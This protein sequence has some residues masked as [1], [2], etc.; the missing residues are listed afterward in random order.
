MLDKDGN[1]ISNIHEDKGGTDMRRDTDKKNRTKIIVAVITNICTVVAAVI[2]TYGVMNAKSSPAVNNNNNTIIL[3]D[4]QQINLEEYN[5]LVAN[6]RSL[7]EK[8]ATLPS[9]KRTTTAAPARPTPLTS[10]PIVD[11]WKSNTA[12]FDSFE[13]NM[14]RDHLDQLHSSGIIFGLSWPS[15]DS[16]YCVYPLDGKYTA[17]NGLF[18][19]TYPARST[20]GNAT[21]YIIDDETKEPLFTS[22]MHTKGTDPEPVTADV[23]G[24]IKLRVF[25]RGTSSSVWEN[26]T[27]G[28]YDTVL[29]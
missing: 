23:T 17:L 16:L 7:Q 18:A 28:L 29:S 15:D 22:K 24:V 12:W 25:V 8:L 6:Y 14:A 9:E 19:V 2:T 11:T 26:V 5:E 27:F 4:G 20:E 3:P 13:G 21:L 10:L 1:P